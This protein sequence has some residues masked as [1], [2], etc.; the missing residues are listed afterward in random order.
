VEIPYESS[1]LQ[2]AFTGCSPGE[3]GVFSYWKVHNPSYLPCIWESNE[4]RRPYLWQWPEFGD[5]T[6]GVLNVFGTHPPYGINGYMITYVFNQSLHCCHPKSLLLD[7]Q[8][9]GLRY[10]HDVSAFYRGQ[11]RDDFQQLLFRISR[12]QIEVALELLAKVD[13]LIANFTL[14]DRLSHFYW[15]EVED[16]SPLGDEDTGLYKGYQ[17][18][19][20][21]VQRFLEVL[22]DDSHLL[23]F[24]DVGFGPLKEFVSFNGYLERMSFLVRDPR[25]HILWDR[26]TAFETVQGSHG[27]NINV[28]PYYREGMIG[29]DSYRSVRDDII[30][31]LRA[32]TNPRTGLPFFRQVVP[33]EEYYA[34]S[35]VGEA[36]HI[37]L[38]PADAR[39]LPRGDEYWAHHV[40]R[41]NQSGWHRPEGFWT[42]R[43]PQLNARCRTGAIADIT[44]TILDLCGK[45]P[46]DRCAGSTL[47]GT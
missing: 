1:A 25:G 3:H 40:H 19:D 18:L 9:Q 12:L 7:L 4:L 46:R 38:I 26:T 29:A 20:T 31:Y 45:P 21:A 34:G 23:L 47:C 22:D 42:G 5:H 13:I 16:G 44:P 27:I 24:S 6:F 43:G 32:L 41:E 10:A 15:Q 39:Y 33:R 2:T 30:S 36:P 17:I 14:A 11:P 37:I 28:R 8:K 35:S